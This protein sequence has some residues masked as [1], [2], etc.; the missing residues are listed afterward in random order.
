MMP[1][2]AQQKDGDYLTVVRSI[3]LRMTKVWDSET[4][5]IRGYDRVRQIKPSEAFVSNICELS[6]LLTDLERDSE[7]CIIRGRFV[8]MDQ[9]QA[10]L[11]GI[12]ERDR[13]S[14]RNGSELKPGYVLR[15]VE[16]FPDRPLHYFMIDI[17]GF[18]PQGVDHMADPEA[19]IA[20]YVETKLPEC[21]HQVSYHWQLSS[22]AGHPDAAGI[23]KAHVW[24]WLKTPQFGQHLKAWVDALNLDIDTCVFEAVQ[25]NYTAAPVFTKGVRDPV[26]R[27]SGMFEGLI[28]DQV[29]LVIP[30]T[31]L[32]KAVAERK[33]RDD[34]VDP[35]EKDNI[36][37]V[38]CRTFEIEEI[39]ERW[40]AEVFELVTDERLTFLLSSSGAKEGA[41]ICDHRQGIFNSHDSDPFNNRA[42]NK[43]DLV[44]VYRFGHL[45]VGLTAEEKEALGMGGLPSQKAMLEMVRGLPE[46]Q[47]TQQNEIDGMF[48]VIEVE[49]DENG[50]I[51]E[52]LPAL[53]RNRNGEILADLNN[54]VLGLNSY[55]VS[56]CYIA[57]DEFK[58]TVVMTEQKDGQGGWR[59]IEDHDAVEFRL[60]LERIGF[61]P[62]SREMMRDVIKYIS[63]QNKFD[64]AIL[65]GKGLKWDGVKRIDTFL[66]KY[67][68]VTDAKY[69]RAISRYMWSAMAGRLMVPGIKA[70]I[71]P[72]LIGLQGAGKSTAVAAMSPFD[73]WFCELDLSADDDKKARMLRGKLVAE[74]GELRGM[75]N[76]E[77]EHIK[78]F[79]S[80]QFEEWVPKFIEYA[81][82]YYRR[83]FFI[84]TSNEEKV[85]VDRTGNRRWA[86]VRVGNVDVEALRTDREQLWAEAIQ[87]F[88]A[89][90]VLFREAEILAK[91]KHSEHMQEDVWLDAISRWLAEENADGVLN[92][93][94]KLKLMDV[95]SGA[96]MVDTA[97]ADRKVQL[98]VADV[99]RDLGFEKT[100]SRSGQVWEKRDFE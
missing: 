87:L 73:D 25:P 5:P 65:W 67:F 18:K 15:R 8:G 28:D 29:D 40:L 42:A 57:W 50:E 74:F 84:G 48:E 93:C 21:F 61:K 11:P 35:S 53:R 90:G 83:T 4:G 19:A 33:K 78:A 82:R 9:A 17:D 96:L 23:L 75:Y 10:A 45:D 81:T 100:H 26:A 66:E 55:R 95:I 69:A 97:R 44:R 79:M 32:A 6:A 85:L 59:P 7:A 80:R 86:P 16:L 47:E 22:S 77:V 46:I 91:A 62:I 68:G 38:F 30:E 76:R 20:Q 52:E 70:D 37:G 71:A 14:G 60:R 92:G 49:R 13:K 1:A 43:W 56:G 88:E 24:F 41:R 63:N 64:S 54:I 36:I 2:I 39:I 3:N 58:G 12:L 27:R 51:E 99:M 34:M 98:R 31:L 89:E 72:I 94:R